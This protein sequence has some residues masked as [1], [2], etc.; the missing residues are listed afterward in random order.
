MLRIESIFANSARTAAIIKSTNG[1][2]KASLYSSESAL[3]DAGN[4]VRY[5]EDIRMCVISNNDSR[6][7]ISTTWHA[8]QHGPRLHALRTVCTF[9]E[10][11]D[12]VLSM[13]NC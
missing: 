7:F 5:G 4:W 13:A 11:L 10:S 1:S 9:S 8:Y 2:F 3:D 12:Y 6:D